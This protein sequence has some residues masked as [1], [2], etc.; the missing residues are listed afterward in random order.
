MGWPPTQHTE[1]AIRNAGQHKC[2]R[3][4]AEHADRVQVCFLCGTEPEVASIRRMQ[5]GE[6]ESTE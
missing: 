6:T 4:L 5:C 3:C 1:R 2:T